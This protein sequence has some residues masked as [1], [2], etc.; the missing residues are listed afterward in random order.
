[1]VRQY[2][3]LFARARK[4]GLKSTVH[5]GETAGT[6]AEGVMAVVEKLKPHRIGHGIRAAYDE[7]AMKLL[8]ERDVVLELCPTSNL[9]HPGGG[10]RSTSS[11][12]SCSTFWDRGVK[13]TINTD[14]PYL[15]DTDM[16]REIDLLAT[17]SCSRTS[18]W[19]RRCAGPG[20]DVRRAGGAMDRRPQR[21]PTIRSTSSSAAAVRA[22]SSGGPEVPRLEAAAA[23]CPTPRAAPRSP[24][25]SAAAGARARQH[26]PERRAEPLRAPARGGEEPLRPPAELEHAPEPLLEDPFTGV[27]ASTSAARASSPPA[28]FSSPSSR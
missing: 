16:R 11:S 28:S 24:G 7:P 17:A 5:T 10:D 9:A 25:S 27:S 4:A 1:M 6:G 14:G 2:E 21:A 13:F 18:R 19:T 26:L 15:L 8:R 22:R 12:T 23:G 3:D 20:G